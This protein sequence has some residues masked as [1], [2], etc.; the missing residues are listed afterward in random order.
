[1]RFGYACQNLTLGATTGRTV[2]LA[3]LSDAERVRSAIDANLRDLETILRWSAGRPLGLFRMSQQIIPFASHPAF[4]YDWEE[5]HGPALR[6]IG[7]L[8]A[9]LGTRLSVHPGQFIQPGSPNRDVARRSLAELR[10]LSRLL[11]LVQGSD[12]VLHLGGACGDRRAAVTRFTA[13]LRGER[14]I[15]RHLALENDERVWTVADVRQAASA[16]GVPVIVDTLH[17][18]LNPGGLTLRSAL[19]LALPTW[20]RPPKVHLSSQDPIKQHG[21]HAF[22]ITPADFA[23]LLSALDGRES[24]VMVEAKGKEQAVLA[25]ASAT[26]APEAIAW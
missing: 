15:L 17:H 8:A 22:N 9:G 18:A 13:S 6:R 4:P 16:L 23:A 20:D 2:R 24:D 21:A 19:D 1:M 7:S 3:N 5:E 12:L 26:P 10:Y 11:S 25:L 14:E